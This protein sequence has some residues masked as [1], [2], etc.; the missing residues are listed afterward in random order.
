MTGPRVYSI[1]FTRK[2]AEKFFGALRNAGIRRLVDV[3]LHNSSMLAG[4]TKAGDLP[5]L[6]RELGGAEYRHELILAPS[7]D[8]FRAIK[9]GT[10][11]WPEYER[12]FLQL[13]AD[14]RVEDRL[15]RAIF[16]VPTVVL[17]SEPAADHCHRRLVLEYLD[18]R[19]GGGLEV[20]HL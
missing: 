1:G 14:R 3:R 12:R 16:S 2:S 5:F 7:E 10:I 13:M 17:C 15:D 6:L 8:L 20:V 9:G 18:R 11:G 4:F 19:W